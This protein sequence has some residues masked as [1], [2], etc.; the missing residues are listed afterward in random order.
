MQG[1]YWFSEVY[2]PLPFMYYS[3]Y[4]LLSQVIYTYEPLVYETTRAGPPFINIICLLSLDTCTLCLL[5]KRGL[6]TMYLNETQAVH[7]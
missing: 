4:L 7:I 6:S 5:A 1:P 2:I 3:I